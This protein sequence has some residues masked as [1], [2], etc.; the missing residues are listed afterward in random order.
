M[1]K[2]SRILM[3]VGLIFLTA[4]AVV[5]FRLDAIAKDSLEANLTKV[6]GVKT[7][8]SALSIN[9]FSGSAKI[10]DLTIDNPEGY[11]APQIFQSQQIDVDFRPAS[12]FGSTLEINS[13]RLNDIDVNF[14]QKLRDNNILELVNH[15]KGKK[16][17]N[18]FPR[19]LSSQISFNKKRFEISTVNLNQIQVNVNL[20]PL[21]NLIP[22]GGFSQELDV[23]IP[24][25]ELRNLNSENAQVVLEGTLDEVVSGLLGNLAGGIF[26]EVPKQMESDEVGSILGDLIENIPF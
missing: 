3:F 10:T 2:L 11:K 1:K 21:G 26:D 16:R 23:Q 4:L 8:V 9:K 18:L 12:L 14:E 6:L 20:S 17:S 19:V 24:D 7:E 5:W 25:I 13:L 15:A 22:F